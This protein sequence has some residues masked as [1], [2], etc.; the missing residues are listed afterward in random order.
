M[1]YTHILA[2]I[3]GGILGFCLACWIAA[4]AMKDHEQQARDGVRIRRDYE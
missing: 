2:L 3:I 4:A 1:I